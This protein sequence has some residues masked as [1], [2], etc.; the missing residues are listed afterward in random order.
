[1]IDDV[2]GEHKIVIIFVQRV[3]A[4]AS[5]R[6]NCFYLFLRLLIDTS[7]TRHREVLD[8]GNRE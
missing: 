4:E 5:K 7:A 3:S 2:V 1:M 8:N 6:N